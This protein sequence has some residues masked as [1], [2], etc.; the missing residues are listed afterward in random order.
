MEGCNPQVANWFPDRSKSLLHNRTRNF[1]CIRL[2]MTAALSNNFRTGLLSGTPTTGIAGGANGYCDD[3]MPADRAGYPHGNDR[4]SQY[5][6]RY[7]GILCARI[8]L[9]LPDR[10]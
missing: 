7:P 8:L 9:F 2:D 4:R 10:A 1:Q 5:L 3:Q 6:R